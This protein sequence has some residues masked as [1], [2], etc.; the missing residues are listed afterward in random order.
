MKK[1]LIFAFGIGAISYYVGCAPVEFARN[2][3]CGDSCVSVGGVKEYRYEV[4]PNEG[5][6]DILFVADNSASMSFEQNKMAERFTDF[7]QELDRQGVDYRI[8]V[9]TTDISSSQNPP[10]AINQNGALQ[11]GR[12]VQMTGGRYFISKENTPSLSERISLFTSIIVRQET[13]QCEAFLKSNLFPTSAQ[14][15]A[16]CPSQDE[17]GLY[18]ATLTVTNNYNNFI[19]TDAHLAIVVLSDE[20]VRSGIYLQSTQYPQYSLAAQDSIEYLLGAIQSRYPGK[21]LKVHSIIVE[22]SSGQSQCLIEQ[23]SQTNG[24]KGSY[25]YIYAQASQRTGGI[26]GNICAHSYTYQL[27]DIADNIGESVYEKQ[28]FCSNP[29]P[30]DNVTPLVSFVPVANSNAYQIEGDVI[31]FNPNLKAGT[32][33]YLQYVCEWD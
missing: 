8:A 5:K 28:L 21:K 13:L 15:E 31:R 22:P 30:I 3:D 6:V 19:R 20:D 9:T 4:I 27:L 24:V 23:N 25:G 11:D 7:I 14:Y 17:R 16:N 2:T 33:A 1:N 18:A 26:I 32:K 29:K 12:L 10:R